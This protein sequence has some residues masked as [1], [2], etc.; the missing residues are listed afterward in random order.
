MSDIVLTK[1]ALL[2]NDEQIS[3]NNKAAS[4]YYKDKNWILL[5]AYKN[6]KENIM[7]LIEICNTLRYLKLQQIILLCLNFRYK[8]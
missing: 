1:I 2:A 3:R 6:D 8:K 5:D 4:F 7:D